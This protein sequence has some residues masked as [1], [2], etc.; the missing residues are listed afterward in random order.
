M[1]ADVC[2]AV[3][4]ELLLL[5]LSA[6]ILPLAQAASSCP[7]EWNPL[8]PLL[9]ICIQTLNHSEDYNSSNVRKSESPTVIKTPRMNFGFWSLIMVKMAC[10]WGERELFPW[11][12]PHVGMW[13]WAACDHWG[14]QPQGLAGPEPVL[15]CGSRGIPGHRAG[16]PAGRVIIG[17]TVPGLLFAALSSWGPSWKGC[18]NYRAGTFSAPWRL[19]SPHTDTWA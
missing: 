9:E 14:R 8:E 6:L 13:G 18:K 10:P 19:S 7:H 2:G 5:F 12:G 3:Q 11:C 15:A 1:Q 17:R 4:A 16:I